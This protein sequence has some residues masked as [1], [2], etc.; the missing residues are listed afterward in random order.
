M[1]FKARFY[2][3]QTDFTLDLD[4]SLPTTGVTALYG[5]SGAGKTSL[6]RLLAGLQRPEAGEVT[7]RDQVWQAGRR[8]LPPHKRPVG[9][10]FQESSLFDHLSVRRN[11]AYGMKRAA[12]APDPA[13]YDH[14]IE[15]L[16]IGPLMDRAPGQLSGGERQRVAIA[17]ALLVRPQVLLM[18]E[19]M[20][21]LDTARKKEILGYLERLKSELNI[22]L[23]YVSH[24]ADEVTRL[25]DHLVVLDRGRLRVQGPIRQVLADH[26]IL[27]SLRGEPF[28]ALFGRVISPSTTHRLTEVAVGDTLFRMPR[29]P[30]REGQDIRLHL[31]ARDVSIA[32]HRPEDSSILNIFDC[33]IEAIE[34]PTPDGQQLVHLRREGTTIQALISAYSCAELQLR[35]GRE[36]YAQIKALSILQ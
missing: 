19:P 25:A 15:L 24:N 22:P 14:I 17:R 2:L 33:R 3:R 20:A 7:F 35:P 34:E 23:L 31:H 28:T 32:L 10:V 11:L 1:A 29:Q 9:F 13:Q 26:D 6:L 36:V 30:V 12:R 16:G 18:D 4:L 5:P 8:F 21:A 27:D